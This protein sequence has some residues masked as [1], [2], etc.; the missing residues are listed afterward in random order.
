MIGAQE[1]CDHLL[2]RGYSFYTGVPCSTF[3][4]VIH[5]VLERPG[6]DYVIAANEGAALGIAAG[7]WLCGRKPALLIQSSGLCNLL[8][9]LTSLSVPYRIPALLFI[10]GRAYPTGEGDE[11]QHQLIG[12]SARGI[13]E[14]LGVHRADMSLSG[15]SDEFARLLDEADAVISRGEM[16]VIMVPPTC[17]SGNG[18][19]LPRVP[20]ASPYPLRRIEAVQL[21]AEAVPKDVAL[22][23]TTGMIS[24]ELY[25]VDDRAGNFY[26]QGSMG[27]ARAIA[28]GIALSRPGRKVVLLDGD[29][30]ALMHLG[31]LSTVGHYAPPNLVEI[32]LDNEAYESTG[33][34]DTTSVTTDLELV[35]RACG[36]P[37]TR[38]CL[39][40][41]ELRA[42][43]AEALREPGPH[44]L[45]VK[46]NREEL[47][48]KVPRITERHTHDGN[49]RTFREFLVRE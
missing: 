13:F 14:C 19:R 49:A 16:A 39:T 34:Q 31:S 45:I 4:D 30:A 23:S 17:I 26:M 24:R 32:V 48:E 9:P 22:V 40:A 38:R 18:A 2:E 12:A 46:V 3:K 6:L 41:E 15:C 35:A 43:L 25:M 20:I 7:A 28:L 21:V 29:G 33:N 47:K 44:F 36:Y 37:R 5:H 27:H 1:L 10:S 42:G 8:N 11:P